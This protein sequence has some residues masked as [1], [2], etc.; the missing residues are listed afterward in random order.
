MSPSAIR[1]YAFAIAAAALLS[2]CETPYRLP[3]EQDSRAQVTVESK[4]D[5][6]INNLN[7][8]G[9]YRGRTELK[10][11]MFIRAGEDGRRGQPVDDGS[12][13]HSATAAD[14]RAVKGMA[15]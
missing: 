14:Q 7:A 15:A 10:G 4:D 6:V 1:S 2:A 9:C 8:E 11:A 3:T 13:R 5:V 12:G